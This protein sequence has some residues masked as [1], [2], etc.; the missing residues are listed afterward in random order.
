MKISTV[1]DQVLHERESAAQLL[2]K[3]RLCPGK[4]ALDRFV[5]RR[6]AAPGFTELKQRS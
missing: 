2:L 3:D 5:N 1:V 6:Q 4:L